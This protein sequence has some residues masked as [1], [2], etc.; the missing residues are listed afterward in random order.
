M[1]FTLVTIAVCV[2]ALAACTVPIDRGSA[3]SKKANKSDHQICRD[4]GLRI[5]SQAY[6]DCRDDLAEKRRRR[7]SVQ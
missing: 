1:K 7:Q 3:V 5:G 2:A 4:Y 6:Y